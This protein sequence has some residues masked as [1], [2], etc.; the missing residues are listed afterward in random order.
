MVKMVH[1][2]YFMNILSQLKKYNVQN[3]ASIEKK[4]NHL[5]YNFKRVG[6]SLYQKLSDIFRSQLISFHNQIRPKMQIS[7][8]MNSNLI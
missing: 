4:E 1:K 7:L 5:K 6:T 3:Y 2:L 8:V